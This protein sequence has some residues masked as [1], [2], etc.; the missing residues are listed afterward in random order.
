MTEESQ[1][2]ARLRKLGRRYGV[3]VLAIVA[4]SFTVSS[5][6]QIIVQ[7]FGLTTSEK[8]PPDDC[9][10]GIRTLES[11]LDGASSKA[12][13]ERESEAVHRAW[14]NGLMPEWSQASVIERTCAQT[15]EG[16]QAYASLVR[17]RHAYEV[18]LDRRS[19]DVKPLRE[20]LEAQISPR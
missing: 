20:N 15:P 13:F 10:R 18:A 5:T 1:G 3:I 2:S 8:V 11:A 17:L 4:L 19:A 14:D 16:T 6:T 12:G 9:V 7:C